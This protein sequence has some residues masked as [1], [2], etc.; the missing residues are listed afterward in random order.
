MEQVAIAKRRDNVKWMKTVAKEAYDL[1][2]QTLDWINEN[3]YH[4]R[5]PRKSKKDCSPFSGPSRDIRLQTNP[6]IERV[7]LDMGVK[8]E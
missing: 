2:F 5:V 4:L 8:P 1:S 3:I 6:D 7:V